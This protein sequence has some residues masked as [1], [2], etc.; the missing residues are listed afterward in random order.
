MEREDIVNARVVFDKVPSFISVFDTAGKVVFPIVGKVKIH[1]ISF[2]LQKFPS[3]GFS[4]YD[5]RASNTP[6]KIKKR[7]C[8]NN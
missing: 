7:T 6:S 2:S 3:V 5:V 4:V 8:N 1:W